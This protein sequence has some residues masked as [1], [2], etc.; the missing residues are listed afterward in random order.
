MQVLKDYH[1]NMSHANGEKLYLTIR[2]KYYYRSLNK[3]CMDFA[4]TCNT[5]LLIKN[6]KMKACPIRSWPTAT[7]FSEISIDHHGPINAKNAT[8][9][10]KYILVIVDHFSENTR[11]IAAKTTSA[12]ETCELLVKEWFAHYG[13]PTKIRSDKSS[14]FLAQ[15]TQELFKYCKIKHMTTAVYH[16]S[17]NGR[18]E[19][20]NSEFLK[21]IRALGKEKLAKWPEY[22]NLIEWSNRS[23]VSKSLNCTPFFAMYG[24]ECQTVFDHNYAENAEKVRVNEESFQWFDEKMLFVRNALKNNLVA[25]NERTEKYHNKTAQPRSFEIGDTVYRLNN[26][27]SPGYTRSHLQLFE[28][29]YVIVGMDK[30]DSLLVTL[31]GLYTGKV[32]KNQTHI[33]QLKRTRQRTTLQQ[34]YESAPVILSTG[35][36]TAAQTDPNPASANDSRIIGQTKQQDQGAGQ[37]LTDTAMNGNLTQTVNRPRVRVSDQQSTGTIVQTNEC[38]RINEPADERTS[39]ITTNS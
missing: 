16:P 19:N 38:T 3:D 24:Q 9:E 18:V 22:L 5:C 8:H 30:Q 20:R 32:E 15:F 1:D 4:K 37:A 14:S 2:D 21:C 12:R 34:K 7:L 17:S 10:Y 25:A 6:A 35:G 23:Q 28:G 33:G 31:A 27:H 29:P 11:Y 36:N 39:G 13:I 26:K